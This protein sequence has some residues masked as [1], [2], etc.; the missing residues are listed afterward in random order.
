MGSDPVEKTVPVSE[1]GAD[2]IG[3]A[4]AP[5]VTSGKK[6]ADFVAFFC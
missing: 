6:V 1:T 4:V 3:S 2:E 5:L